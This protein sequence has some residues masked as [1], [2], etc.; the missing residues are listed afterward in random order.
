VNVEDLGGNTGDLGGISYR[1]LRGKTEGY[2][3]FLIIS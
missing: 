1:Y 3:P 2:G